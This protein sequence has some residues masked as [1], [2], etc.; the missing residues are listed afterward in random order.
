MKALRRKFASK[1]KWTPLSETIKADGST[2]YVVEGIKGFDSYFTK[3]HALTKSF[4]DGGQP[5]SWR[6]K[7]IS[8]GIILFEIIGCLRLLLLIYTKEVWVWRLSGDATCVLRRRE[9][10]LAFFLQAFVLVLIVRIILFALD[11]SGGLK[12]L[13][14]FAPM[15]TGFSSPEDFFFTRIQLKKFAKFMALYYQV[16]VAAVCYI[17]PG[18]ITLLLSMS[19]WA[20]VNNTN[21]IPLIFLLINTAFM[22]MQTVTITGLFLP[23][24]A[25]VL[26]SVYFAT[27]QLNNLKQELDDSL[28][29]SRFIIQS[30]LDSFVTRFN[31]ISAFIADLN[32]LVKYIYACFYFACTPNYCFMIYIGIYGN[33]DFAVKVFI[34]V[35]LSQQVFFVALFNTQITNLGVEAHKPYNLLNSLFA[36]N[37]NLRMKTKLKVSGLIEKLAGPTIGIYCLDLFAVTPW[38]SFEYYFMVMSYFILFLD[39]FLVL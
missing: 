5:S 27:N 32:I 4:A 19:F 24:L 34:W 16:G 21:E 37:T 18:A 12:Y 10:F 17:L 36:R 26:A 13:S 22:A 29:K 23:L 31:R 9:M 33:V 2:R 7:A 28:G 14:I 35:C 15:V 39:L 8:L 30:S 25:L 3:T 38:V 1:Y 6:K 11:I 20:Y